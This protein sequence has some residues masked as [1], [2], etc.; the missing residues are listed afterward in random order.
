MLGNEQVK[1]YFEYIVVIDVLRCTCSVVLQRYVVYADSPHSNWLTK[2]GSTY[3]NS[4]KSKWMCHHTI[5]VSQAPFDSTGFSI[6]LD[7]QQ[8]K[9]VMIPTNWFKIAF[10]DDWI[11]LCVIVNDLK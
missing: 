6:R 8:P 9:W 3:S 1:V 4:V 10:G 7:L 11:E 2:C 5:F